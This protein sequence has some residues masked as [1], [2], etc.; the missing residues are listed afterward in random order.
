LTAGDTGVG[1]VI[2]TPV[3]E[4]TATA[5][6]PAALESDGRAGL[7]LV[8]APVAASSAS[9]LQIAS[10][11]KFMYSYNGCAGKT[12][13]RQTFRDEGWETCQRVCGI[14]GY[15]ASSGL[16]NTINLL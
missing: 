6:V 8:Q 2:V 1:D 16:V 3:T 15:E 4:S 11:F 9:A 13:N 10:G 7:A 5:V 12:A 14:R